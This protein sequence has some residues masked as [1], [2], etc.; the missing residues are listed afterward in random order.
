MRPKFYTVP[1][2]D[3][4]LRPVWSFKGVAIFLLGVGSKIVPRGDHPRLRLHLFPNLHLIISY[5]MVR[6][7]FTEK[8]IYIYIYIYT[9]KPPKAAPPSSGNL[10]EAAQNHSPDGCRFGRFTCT[11]NLRVA[12]TSEKRHKIILPMG[13]ALGG[14]PVYIYI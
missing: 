9:G 1:L 13:A 10:R 6:I 3:F 11:S 2:M 12:A 7:G 5:G 8:D 4:E 14:L